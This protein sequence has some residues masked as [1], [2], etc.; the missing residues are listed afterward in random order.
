MKETTRDEQE[1][2]YEKEE[3]KEREMEGG[4]RRVQEGKKEEADERRE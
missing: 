1:R 3:D 4:V 2:R